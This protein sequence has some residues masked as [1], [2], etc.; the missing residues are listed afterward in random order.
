MR[1]EL[2][3]TTE[4]MKKFLRDRGYT[5]ESVIINEP[6]SN[7]SRIPGNDNLRE[8]LIGYKIDSD[9]LNGLG[10]YEKY[11]KYGLENQFIKEIKY[12][13]LHNN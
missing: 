12:K 4:E 10:S 2:D 9:N 13:L 5:I 1:L 11:S 3:F 6:S 8:V 7:N